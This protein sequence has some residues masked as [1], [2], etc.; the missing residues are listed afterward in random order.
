VLIADFFSRAGE[1]KSESDTLILLAQLFE[2]SSERFDQCLQYYQDALD[3]IGQGAE[4]A[5]P[6]DIAALML[7]L[8]SARLKKHLKD[9][10]DGAETEFVDIEATEEELRFVIESATDL[11]DLN[12]KSRAELELSTVS[13]GLSHASH[14]GILLILLTQG[15]NA[16]GTN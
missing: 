3:A 11:E 6:S 16:N 13:F 15:A 4:D 9:A 5:H 7:R 1:G 10:S 14:C 12:L 8:A 2:D